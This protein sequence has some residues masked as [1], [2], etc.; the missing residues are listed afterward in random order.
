MERIDK[1]NDLV[2]VTV[3]QLSKILSIISPFQI[4]DTIYNYVISK[5]HCRYYY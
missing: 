1:E 3:E 4:A 2:A 5:Q